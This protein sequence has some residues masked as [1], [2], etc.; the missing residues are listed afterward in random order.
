MG[1]GGTVFTGNSKLFIG[2]L[3]VVQIGFKGYDLGKTTADTTLVPDQD[4]KDIMYQQDG[5]KAADHIKTGI[6]YILNA[7]FGEISTG[8]VKLLMSGIESSEPAAD[9]G[10]VLGRSIF[11]S[12]LDNEAGV[13]KVAA[14]D[15]YGVPFTD[16]EHIL[17]FYHVIP[18]ISGDLV[19]WGVD[20][21]RNLPVEF[22]I[23]YHT[24]TAAELAA[25]TR[26]EGGAFGYWGDPTAEDVTPIVWPD[27]EGPE[28]VSA[29]ATDAVTMEVVF[30]EVF[31]FQSSFVEAHWAARVNGEY[32]LA[33]AGVIDDPTKKITLTFPAATFADG[34]DIIHLSISEHAIQDEEAV[35]NLYPGIELYP[36]TPWAGA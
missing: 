28:I 3:G 13:M 15:E 23:K 17:N 7:T 31:D 27:K 24:F 25:L 6:D 34:D 26:N 33:T 18:I 5:T 30:N 2:P 9:D 19:N 29:I 10:G 20:T 36:C 21:Q 22:R 12:M 14:V 16:L 32:I 35:P 8:L 1:L 11:K 4:I